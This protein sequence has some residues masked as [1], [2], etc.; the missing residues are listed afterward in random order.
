MSDIEHQLQQQI[1]GALQDGKPLNI[2]GGN[3]KSH[4]GRASHGETLRVSGHQG[5]CSY[6]PTEL[7]I[8]ARAG[9]RVEEIEQV[10][11]QHNQMLPF[12]PPHYGPDA[13]IGGTI[14]CN[15]SG[16]A[17]VSNGAARDFLLG[18]R[19]INGKAQVLRFGGEVMKN[20]AGYDASRLMCG[21]M[22]TLGVLLEVSLK[23]LP[24]PA[25]EVTLVQEMTVSKA[26]QFMNECA[27][28]PLPV[29]ASAWC[30]GQLYIRLSGSTNAINTAQRYIGGE[31]LDCA[32]AFWSQMREHQLAFFQTDKPLWRISLPSTSPQFSV[33]GE[34]LIEWGGALRWL[35]TDAPAETIFT[36][37][38][39]TG[40]HAMCYAG[41]NRDAQIFQPLDTGLMA[42]HRQLK[43]SFDPH[44][45]F[46]PGRMY[47]E[48]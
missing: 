13:T 22:G 33:D 3:S 20:V 11:S 36:A 8:T 35:I 32:A 15:L 10:L 37:A 42:L 34:T 12:E 23:V 40:G 6:E 24:K 46:N 43:N 25:T 39:T 27:G 26:I 45:I 31:V 30:N 18:T 14:A 29:S 21:A 44:G 4:L 5:I 7:V 47:Q 41:H 19:M 48:F 17:R 16:P 38:A 9:T 28:M 1:E 2:V